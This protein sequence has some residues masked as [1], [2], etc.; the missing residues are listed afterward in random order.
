MTE[1]PKKTVSILL[2]E[3]LYQELQALAAE[4]SRSVSAYVRQVLT[5]HLQYLERF[6][7]L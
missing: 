4:S 1:K 5:A 2:P 6:R 7:K 3:N